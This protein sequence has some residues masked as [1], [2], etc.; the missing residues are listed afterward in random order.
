MARITDHKGSDWGGSVIGR[1]QACKRKHFWAMEYK[2]PDAD[3]GRGIELLDPRGGTASEFGQLIHLGLQALYLNQNSGFMLEYDAET[4]DMVD[5]AREQ[6]LTYAEACA[7]AMQLAVNSIK[8]DFPTKDLVQD[9]VIACLDQYFTKYEVDDLKPLKVEYPTNVQIGDII[10]TGIIDL[11]ADWQSTTGIVDH[12][13]TSLGWEVFFKKWRDNLSLKGY[14]YMHWR[15]TGDLVPIIINGI[16]RK[17]D[18]ALTC[19][20][21]RELLSYTEADMADFV[22]TVQFE[23]QQMDSCRASE[24]WPKSGDQCVTVYGD[25]EFRRLCT[26]PSDAMVKTF[27][28]PREVR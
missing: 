21:Q 16:R 22:R 15:S 17:K 14:V 25:C 10:H 5:R 23:R 4:S 27:Y 9:E 2:H 8:G 6:P 11:L 20:F 24:F 19:E 7:Q 13:T 18:K 1:F 28:K 12:K 26:F 3:G